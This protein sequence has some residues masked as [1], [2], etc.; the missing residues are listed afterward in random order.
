MVR[1]KENVRAGDSS[2]D[3]ISLNSTVAS[4]LQEEYVIDGGILAERTVEGQAQY[5]VKWDGYDEHCNTW[6]PEENF[7]SSDTLKEWLKKK[8]RVTRGLD[9]AFDLNA[10]EER[11]D[12][13]LDAIAARKQ[14]RKEKRRRHGIQVESSS[15]S[16]D[17]NST[18]S[19]SPLLPLT[20]K[21]GNFTA[22]DVGNQ[23][24]Q[25]TTTLRPGV[26][27]QAWADQER[28]ALEAGIVKVEGPWWNDILALYGRN[29]TVN[30]DLKRMD[31][32]D[33]KRMASHMRKE[34]LRSGRNLPF[35]L[36]QVFNPVLRGQ[37]LA[38][39]TTIVSEKPLNNTASTASLDEADS[40]TKPLPNSSNPSAPIPTPSRRPSYKG[41][42]RIESARPTGLRVA[43]DSSKANPSSPF[44]QPSAQAR[45]LAG[46]P[47]RSKVAKGYQ[48]IARRRSVPSDGTP[49]T[50][51]SETPSGQ[52]RRHLGARGAGPA[53]PN[54]AKTKSSSGT[55][56][57]KQK[58]PDG[59]TNITNRSEGPKL[60]SNLATLNKI[61]K[62]GRNEPAPNLDSLAL[63]NPSTG[64]PPRTLRPASKP[65]SG[66]RASN[67]EPHHDEQPEGAHDT[68]QHDQGER[69]A[70]PEVAEEFDRTL[71]STF[72]SVKGKEQDF[73]TIPHSITF[74]RESSES[75]KDDLFRRRAD[76]LLVNGH[77]KVGLRNPKFYAVRL[78][79]FD[80]AL[81]QLL[82]TIKIPP[83]EVHFELQKTCLAAEY[84]DFLGLVC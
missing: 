56:K 14:R 25:P 27:P 34:F 46:L 64:K 30:E 70:S 63:I 5:L 51:A 2:D 15:S 23:E 18:D 19:D 48:K 24:N 35:W 37:S 71:P 33:L 36:T 26:Q 20:P 29:G 79:V 65:S 11:K 43:L 6:E 74:L 8:M 60:F 16:L 44:E 17:A 76:G 40:T 10:Y 47:E 69:P 61:Y 22:K 59:P 7:Q 45:A 1:S 75:S 32:R 52:T 3:S 9:E 54:P 21:R 81:Q 41:T 68:V 78:E 82:L 57:P 39:E 4:E 66:D 28:R 58:A 73:T 84:R 83:R 12:K 53:R 31:E 67:S 77:L 55:R 50:G 38:K 49:V 80:W 13:I 72:T 62:K 42:A